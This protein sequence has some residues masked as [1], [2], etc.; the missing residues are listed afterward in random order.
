[1]RRVPRRPDFDPRKGEVMKYGSTP[2]IDV[3]QYVREAR[4][5]A[6]GM[7]EIRF[8]RRMG[9]R[10][11]GQA[12]IVSSITVESPAAIPYHA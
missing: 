1:M 11:Y 7:M 8:A 4:A 12:A 6:I 2:P 10:Q 9:E 5:Q 3:A